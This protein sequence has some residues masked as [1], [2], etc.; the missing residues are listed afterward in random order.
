MPLTVSS[1]HAMSDSDCQTRYS[2]VDKSNHGYVLET[3]APSYFAFYRLDNKQLTD[4][5]LSKDTFLK[6]CVARYYDLT[7]TDK[8]AP[9]SGANS[10]TEEQAKDRI[11]AHGGSTVSDLNK[12]DKG[13]WRGTAMIDGAKQTVA[14]DYKGNVVFTK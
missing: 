12:D 13:I 10:F 14:L 11:V 5:K 7:A 3:E 4:G 2:S 6:D 9:L 8:D 1:A